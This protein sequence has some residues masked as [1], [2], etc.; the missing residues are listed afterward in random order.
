MTTLRVLGS[1]GVGLVWGWLLGSFIC[2]GGSS[3]QTV[4]LLCLSTLML[5]LTVV[6]FADWSGLAW[7]SGALLFASLL[8]VGWRQKL[9]EH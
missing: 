2:R 3:W 6:L 5:G 4:M 9:T 7:F 1:I 8:H